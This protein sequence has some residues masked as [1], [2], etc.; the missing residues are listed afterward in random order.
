[1]LFF[2]SLRSGFVVT[3][4]VLLIKIPQ[5]DWDVKPAGPF[6]LSDKSREMPSPIYFSPSITTQSS[7]KHYTQ[8]Y[9]IYSIL[10]RTSAAMKPAEVTQNR[11]WDHSHL[12]VQ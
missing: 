9:N 7:P 11:K 5:S 12:Y 2:F 3:A 1:M 6:E 4:Y 10:I 8:R